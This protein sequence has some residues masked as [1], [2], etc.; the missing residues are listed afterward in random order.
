MGILKET[1]NEN[2]ALNFSTLKYL[3]ISPLAYKHN[4]THPKEQTTA[5]ALGTAV[6]CCALQGPDIYSRRFP[7]WHGDRRGKE[8]T[9]F[10]ASRPDDA[11]ILK[12]TEDASVRASAEAIHKKIDVAE[13]DTEQPLYWSSNG[14]QLKSRLDGV[15]KTR[16][17][18]LE[19]KCV[20]FAYMDPY[21]FS[22]H[23]LSM[24]W[25]AQLAMY[26]DAMLFNGYDPL[27]VRLVVAE[28]TAP[29]DVVVYD[30]P[31]DVIDCGRKTYLRW[32]DVYNECAR[33]NKWGAGRSVDNVTLRLPAYAYN[34]NDKLGLTIEGEEV[35][36]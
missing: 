4:L 6:H 36:L 10:K 21:K 3:E 22:S 24:Q 25:H 2:L 7:V 27:P 20:S 30:V 5:M 11:I 12:D 17:G 28:F 1:Y 15:A 9:A 29:Y 32:I 31:Q 8:Y 18:M 13:Y 33:A 14:V 19:L 34:N 23:V 16:K 26:H 35:D